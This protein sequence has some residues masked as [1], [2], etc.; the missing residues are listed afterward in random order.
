[1]EKLKIAAFLI[2]FISINYN[3]KSQN[4]DTLQSKDVF[5]MLNKL[6]N[7][8]L[9][10]IDG[11]DSLM[12]NSGHLEN[13]IYID[14]FSEILENGLSKYTKN[15]S[16]LIY[17]SNQRRSE[18]IIEKLIEMNFA[19]KIIYMQDGLNGWKQNNYPL[20]LE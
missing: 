5:L 19:G 3:L 1:M 9:Q 8:K 18:T 4:I 14:A 6:E 7:S 12:F 11:R 16:L 10:I 17:C 15:D 20:K 13:S 2:F